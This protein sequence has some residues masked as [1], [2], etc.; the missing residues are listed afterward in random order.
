MKLAETTEEV[1]ALAQA[2]RDYW[3]AEL[4][5]RHPNYPIINPGEDS[6]PPPP[7]EKKLRNL[8]ARLPE[9]VI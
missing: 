5:R 6:G 1:I 7:E 8:L 9:D 2:V 4:P 3:N